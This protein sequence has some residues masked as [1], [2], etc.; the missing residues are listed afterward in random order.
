[1]LW[2]PLNE[3]LTGLSVVSVLC[4]FLSRQC[5][6]VENT[7]EPVLRSACALT[8]APATPLTALANVSQAGL[9]TTVHRVRTNLSFSLFAFSVSPSFI[10]FFSYCSFPSIFIHLSFMDVSCHSATLIMTT[11][12]FLCQIPHKTNNFFNKLLDS[13][14]SIIY[15]AQESSNMK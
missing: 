5:V 8:M 7:G 10:V 1:M 15:T 13:T 9:E 6:P 3:W 12:I 14:L 2:L 11:S 4:L